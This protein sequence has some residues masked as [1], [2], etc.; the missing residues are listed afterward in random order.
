MTACYLSADK[1]AFRVKEVSY[2][3]YRINKDGVNL[4]V[5]EVEAIKKAPEPMNK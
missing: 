2:L 4:L 3:G 1:C 5:E